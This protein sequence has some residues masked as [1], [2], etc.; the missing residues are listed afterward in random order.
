MKSR[1]VWEDAGERTFVVVLDAGD[2]EHDRRQHPEPD[3]AEDLTAR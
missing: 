1:L 2:E 3:V